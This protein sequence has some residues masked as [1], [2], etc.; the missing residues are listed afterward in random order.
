MIQNQ[1]RIGVYRV[2]CKIKNFQQ[3]FEY[4]FAEMPKTIQSK[5][6]KKTKGS[7]TNLKQKF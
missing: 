5:T 7:L 1:N 4:F 2:K 6:K 3:S